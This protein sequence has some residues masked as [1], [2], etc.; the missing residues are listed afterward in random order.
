VTLH[1]WRVRKDVTIRKDKEKVENELKEFK[2]RKC[3]KADWIEREIEYK[4][5]KEKKEWMKEK[6]NLEK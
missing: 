6:E 1:L 2:K 3:K 4:D 5:N